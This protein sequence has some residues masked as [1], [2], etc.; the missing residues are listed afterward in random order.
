[1]TELNCEVDSAPLITLLLKIP[2]IASSLTI[3]AR[4][5]MCSTRRGG[6]GSSIRT[7]EEKE[8]IMENEGF[9]FERRNDRERERERDT[10]LF[11]FAEAKL[12]HIISV[13][14]VEDSR[15]G[16]SRTQV[17]GFL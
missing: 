11:H 17:A 6:G 14:H 10:A 3:R 16:Y 12:P 1:M 4:K 2:A 8:R 15:L 5:D 9:E 13:R 7:A